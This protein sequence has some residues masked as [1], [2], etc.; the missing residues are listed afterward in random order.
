[1]ATETLS[2]INLAFNGVPSAHAQARQ[3]LLEKPGSRHANKQ[4]C[5]FEERTYLSLAAKASPKRFDPIEGE[6]HEISKMAAELPKTI[7]TNM[8]NIMKNISEVMCFTKNRLEF[9]INVLQALFVESWQ[10]LLQRLE[11]F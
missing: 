2:P 7:L 9:F 3:L 11:I 1:M 6:A 10:I 4:T 8:E 5:D